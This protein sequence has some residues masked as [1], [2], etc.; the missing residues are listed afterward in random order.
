MEKILELNKILDEEIKFCEDF[1]ELLL[2]KKEL[3]MHSKVLQLKAFDE[4]IY[5]AQKRLEQISQNRSLITQKF[6][7]ENAKLSEIIKSIPNKVEANK[8]EEKRKKIQVSTQKITL[9]N[10]I[11]NSLIEHSLKIIDGSIFSIAAAIE[12]SQTKGDYYNNLGT[13]QK[14]ETMTLS[15]IIEDA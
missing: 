6:G 3:V 15:A 8:L 9:I 11:I 13:K 12:K 5:A 14:Q 1:E 7:D 2:Q 4:K 10:K